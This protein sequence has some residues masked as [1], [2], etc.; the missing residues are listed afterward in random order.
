M[1]HAKQL[2][3]YGLLCITAP[4]W[5]FQAKNVHETKKEGGRIIVQSHSIFGKHCQQITIV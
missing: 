4:L 1:S 5:P 3:L 2:K